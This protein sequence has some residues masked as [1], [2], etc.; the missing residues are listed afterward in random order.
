MKKTS[1]TWIRL[2]RQI[3][4]GETER[5]RL[6]G[7]IYN[8]PLPPPPQKGIGNSRSGGSRGGEPIGLKKFKGKYYW[9]FQ[10]GREVFKKIPSVGRGEGSRY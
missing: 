6:P 9:N 3:L 4:N 8:T 10:R 5:S 7:N 2:E 1:K